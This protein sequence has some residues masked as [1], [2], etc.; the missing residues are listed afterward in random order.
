MDVVLRFVETAIV[1]IVV[2]GVTAGVGAWAL[3]RS[4]RK[5]VRDLDDRNTEQHNQNATLM[6]HLSRQV[7]GIDSKIDRL[8]QRLDHVQQWAAEHEITHLI[9][10]SAP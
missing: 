7:G 9:E 3:I 10:D 4:H 8:D 5:D 1:P 2:A 6:T